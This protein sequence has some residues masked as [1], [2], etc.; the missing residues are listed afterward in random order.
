MAKLFNYNPVYLG[1]VFKKETG[2]STKEYA[3]KKRIDYA[4]KPLNNNEMVISASQKVGFNN[5]TYFNSIFKK[6]AGITPS[7]Y[8]KKATSTK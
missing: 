7:E 3:N 6:L 4:K 1:R 2:T 8:K 5:V